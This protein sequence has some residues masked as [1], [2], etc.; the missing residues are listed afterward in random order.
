[1][2]DRDEFKTVVRQLLTQLRAEG[3]ASGKFL[4]NRIPIKAVDGKSNKSRSSFS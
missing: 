4:L 1:M 3:T 2:I